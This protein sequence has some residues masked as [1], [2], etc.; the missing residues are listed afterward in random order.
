[1]RLQNEKLIY[2]TGTIMALGTGIAST[3]GQQLLGNGIA[4]AVVGA[5]GGIA[6][7]LLSNLAQNL[8]NTLHKKVIDP[9]PNNLNHDLQKTLMVAVERALKNTITL[10]ADTKPEENALEAA[11]DFNKQ[12]VS[13]LLHFFTKSD[14]SV[15]YNTQIQTYIHTPFEDAHQAVLFN[16]EKELENPALPEGFAAFFAHTFTAQ[17]RLCFS[18]ELKDKDNHKSWVAYQKMMLEVTKNDLNS[19]LDGQKKIEQKLDDLKEAQ[20][21]SKLQRLPPQSTAAVT[22]LLREINQPERIQI[23]LDKALDDLLDEIRGNLR[24]VKQLVEITHEELVAFRQSYEKEKVGLWNRKLVIAYGVILLLMATTLLVYRH[25]SNLPFMVTVQV[26]GPGGPHDAV[27][28]GKI[29]ASLTTLNDLPGEILDDK[30]RAFFRNIAGRYNGD[31]VKISL[32]GLEGEPY[33]LVKTQ[34]KLEKDAVLYVPLVTVG[35]D[36]INGIIVDEKR[37]P[38]GSA[39]VTVQDIR[40]QTDDNGMF[41]V[42]IP[43][44]K[45]LRLQ[46]ISISKKGFK[47]ETVYQVAPHVQTRPLEIMLFM[48]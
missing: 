2:L 5:G 28:K 20:L 42:L 10:Y 41:T 47:Q 45:Q 4:S 24:R 43:T 11:R 34:F 6:I 40:T 36:K 14:A 29:T 3:I 30:G 38:V 46:D 27:L 18:E 8:C 31:S 21:S 48:E 12:I 39:I 15:I 37:K 23:Q 25:Y 33:K 32:S 26:H 22:R 44:E 9:H 7:N 1:M 35:L 16:L 19:L 17:F 13:T